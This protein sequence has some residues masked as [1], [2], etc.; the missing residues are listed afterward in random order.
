MIEQTAI[1]TIL[2]TGG[3]GFIGSNFVRCILGSSAINVVNLDK[4]TYA[5]NLQNL[6]GIDQQ[7]RSR[8]QFVRADICDE[9]ALEKIFS[10]HH[11]DAIV[12]FA[13]ESHVDRSISGPEPFLNTNYWGTYR[14]LEQAKSH[15]IR[16]L[17]VSTDEVYGSVPGTQKSDEDANLNPSSPYSASKAA[18]D[19]LVR[20]YTHTFGVPSIIVRC[21]NNYG[22]YQFPEKLIPLVIANCIS[23][24]PIPVYGSGSNIRDWLYVE[25]CCRAIYAVLIKG[26]DSEIYNIGE[27][28]PRSNLEVVR[29]IIQAVGSSDD[30]ISFVSDRPGHDE[31]YAVS[32]EKIRSELGW[33]PRVDFETGL[34]KT[35]QWYSD[36]ALWLE[37]CRNGAY[38]RYYE[39][40]YGSRAQTA[41]GS[42]A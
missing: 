34:R 40:H 18:A 15:R 22:P 29:S 35:I 24:K 28:A 1:K 21:A 37:N 11:F 10:A 32:A 42:R 7:Y 16:F 23:Q 25:D 33:R 13:A 20:S 19:L 17:Q 5:G 12:N 41:V 31:R 27:V 38:Q 39:A 4:L 30:L 14:L 2:I 8:Y 26:K 6:E 36:H 3:A 9:A